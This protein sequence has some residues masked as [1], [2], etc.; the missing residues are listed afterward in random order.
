MPVY[1]FRCEQ[2]EAVSS[3]Y[4]HTV[5]AS[6]STQCRYC[7]SAAVQRIFSAFASPQSE[8]D[9]MRRLDP[10]Y[11]RQVD[12]ALA[13]APATTDPN[14][15]LRQMVPFHQAKEAGKPPAKP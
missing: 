10:K 15:Y 13:R 2:C 14:H 1:E 11:H 7:G 8:A 3:V 5:T 12:A 6:P 9:K 4:F